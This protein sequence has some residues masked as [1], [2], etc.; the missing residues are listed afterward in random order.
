MQTSDDVREERERRDELRYV[1]QA[2]QANALVGV[3]QGFR[4]SYDNKSKELSNASGN[5]TAA[6]YT[7]YQQEL[8]NYSVEW[9]ILN[10]EIEAACR[11]HATLVYR[12]ASGSELDRAEERY[13]AKLDSARQLVIDVER[14]RFNSQD[15]DSMASH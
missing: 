14:M 2:C 6:R 11:T 12:G 9:E 13:K 10:R 3:E 5:L 15:P 4:L 8:A 7:R 1:N